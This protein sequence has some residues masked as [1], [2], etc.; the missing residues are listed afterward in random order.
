M[1]NE[2]KPII[3]I[4]ENKSKINFTSEWLTLCSI[5]CPLHITP[6]SDSV[7]IDV[8]IRSNVIRGVAGFSHITVTDNEIPPPTSDIVHLHTVDSVWINVCQVQ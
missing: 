6:R 2:I 4:S 5:P 7:L 1:Y 3:L 8:C